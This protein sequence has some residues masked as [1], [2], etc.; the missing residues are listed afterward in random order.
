MFEL[1]SLFNSL[2]FFEVDDLT[3]VDGLF[4]IYLLFSL[5]VLP[6]SLLTSIDVFILILV[7]VLF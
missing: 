5:E 1:Y 4:S 3:V 6:Q 7:R 2:K